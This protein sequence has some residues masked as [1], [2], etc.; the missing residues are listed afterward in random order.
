MPLEAADVDVRLRPVLFKEN[1]VAKPTGERIEFADYEERIISQIHGVKGEHAGL[2]AKIEHR[3]VLPKR[4]PNT[5]QMIIVF[6]C[7]EDM[8]TELR[9]SGEMVFGDSDFTK[10]LGR[11]VRA[12]THYMDGSKDVTLV[13][14]CA[15]RKQRIEWEVKRLREETEAWLDENAW[16]MVKQIWS[17]LIS[18]L[19]PWRTSKK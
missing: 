4:A 19:V 8:L 15:A 7:N 6:Y 10:S 1:P 9:K 12:G 17:R 13:M 5:Q 3:I 16:N 18:K 11:F 2:R 14:E